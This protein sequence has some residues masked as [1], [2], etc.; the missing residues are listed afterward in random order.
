MGIQNWSHQAKG[1]ISGPCAGIAK[2]LLE[3]NRD[4]LRWME[5]LFTG[6]CNLKG[7]LFKV[8]LTDDRTYERCQKE[9]ESVTHILC[10]C[11][12]VAHVRFRHLGQ[13]FMEPVDHCDAPINKVLKFIRSVG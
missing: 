4:Q 1:L 7:H 5:G 3:L 8:G 10:D 2:D 13:F 9:D 6:Q 12:A 11:E